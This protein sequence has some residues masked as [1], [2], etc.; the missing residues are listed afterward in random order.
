MSLRKS[1]YL[2]TSRIVRIFRQFFI[3]SLRHKVFQ[4]NVSTGESIFY[5]SRVAPSSS[6]HRQ[7]RNVFK[8]YESKEVELR[9]RSR[10][11]SKDSVERST[12]NKFERRSSDQSHRQSRRVGKRVAEYPPRLS[13]RLKIQIVA[14]IQR[15]LAARRSAACRFW[16]RHNIAASSSRRAVKSRTPVCQAGGQSRPPRGGFTSFRTR[17]DGSQI[18]LRRFIR[19]A[20][21]SRR[22]AKRSNCKTYSKRMSIIS[23]ALYYYYS[24]PVP[25]FHFTSP[26][27]NKRT[28]Y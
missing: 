20:K 7:E 3:P 18:L 10:G 28:T 25:R 22:R 24:K 19:L 15:Y 8:R 16:H 5:R 2:F 1:Y 12:G 17:S 27:Y 26:W 21:R 9:N 14:A 4:G 13:P 23:G 6:S 11:G